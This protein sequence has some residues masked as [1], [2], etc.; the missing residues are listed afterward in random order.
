MTEKTGNTQ[1]EKERKSMAPRAGQT[2]GREGPEFLLLPSRRD[3]FGMAKGGLATAIVAGVVAS[4]FHF[5]GRSSDS[6]EAASKGSPRQVTIIEFSDDGLKK[7]PV[8]RAKVVKTTA[9]W[10]AQ[11]SPEQ[12]DV[13]R[14]AGT[15]P[16]FHNEYDELFAAGLYRCICCDNALYSSKTKFNSGTGWPSFWQ[17]IARENVDE[18]SDISLGGE[19]TEVLC[20]LCDAHL[21]HVFNDG[22][23]PTGLRYCMNSAAMKFVA[24]KKA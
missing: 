16:P 7:G 4:G 24:A 17:P 18:R 12:Y 2:A 19:R 23:P 20:K 6:S 10:K 15:E 21:G 9:E 13:T 11:L 8:T 1:A 14:E 22:P 3:F 5:Y